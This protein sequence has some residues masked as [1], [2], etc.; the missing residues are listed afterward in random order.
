MFKK[1]TAVFS[2][3][4]EALWWA[5]G[6]LSTVVPQPLKRWAHMQAATYALVP[7]LGAVSSA[8]PANAQ[9][10]TP[11]PEEQDALVKAIGQVPH[12]DAVPSLEGG[13]KTLHTLTNQQHLDREAE[14]TGKVRIV[15]S[16][17]PP[18]GDGS[19]CPPSLL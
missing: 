7:V 18:G 1:I 16:G 5:T 3:L 9:G 4:S 17:H 11:E 10:G 2:R 8:R 13:H 6:L 12:P 14:T 19:G 15:S